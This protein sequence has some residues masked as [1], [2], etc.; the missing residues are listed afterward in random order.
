VDEGILTVDDLSLR[1]IVGD[2]CHPGT[3]FPK[4]VARGSH[5]DQ[6]AF[7]MIAVQVANGR[8][9]HHHITE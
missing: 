1:I 6:E 2:R 4:R 7:R 8:C 3:V 5:I 9:Q